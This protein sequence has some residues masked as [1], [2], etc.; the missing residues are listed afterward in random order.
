M[1][2]SSNNFHE[3][4]GSIKRKR[5]GKQRKK[6]REKLR[7]IHVTRFGESFPGHRVDVYSL[8]DT[9]FSLLGKGQRSFSLSRNVREIYS[10]RIFLEN[11]T[12]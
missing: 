8:G 5:E 1:Y 11:A 3:F 12:R 4:D 6:E 7:I 10:R 9:E 2:V